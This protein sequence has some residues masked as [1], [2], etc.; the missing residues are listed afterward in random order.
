MKSLN[1]LLKWGYFNHPILRALACKQRCMVCGYHYDSTP[2]CRHCYEQMPWNRNACQHCAE[3]LPQDLPATH[4][5]GACHRFDSIHQVLAPLRFDF[6][7]APIVSRFKYQQQLT[8]SPLLSQLFLQWLG[9]QMTTS[10]LPD[11]LVAVP[12]HHQRLCQRGFNQSLELAHSLGKA[13]ELPHL[14]LLSKIKV[15]EKQAGLSHG[16]RQNNLKHSFSVDKNAQHWA[17]H[18]PHIAIVDDVVTTGATT[19]LLAKL[20]KQQGFERVDVWAIARTAK[21]S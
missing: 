15:T 13:L 20:L 6:P 7:V 19:N 2:C 8:L 4:Y 11:A 21:Q 3:P 9:T 14:Q 18:Y 10:T 17:T 16:E 12:V 1:Q 5:C